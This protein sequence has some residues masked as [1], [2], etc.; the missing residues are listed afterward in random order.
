MRNKKYKVY[1][2]DNFHYMDE[3]SRLTLGKYATLEEALVVCRKIVDG[4]LT[5]FYKPKISARKLYDKYK[6][7]GDDPWIF[8]E[9]E[10]MH[11]SAWDYAKKRCSELTNKTK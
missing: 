9:P 3:E 4:N 7:F 1:V 11:F 10:G 2:D 6:T 8:G 5:D